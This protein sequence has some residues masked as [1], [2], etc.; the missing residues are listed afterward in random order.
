M[1][2][3]VRRAAFDIRLSNGFVWKVRSETMTAQWIQEM[4]AILGLSCKPG[5]PD[6]DLWVEQAE[7]WSGRPFEP[8]TL[9]DL[10]SHGLVSPDRWGIRAWPGLA[11]LRHEELAYVIGGLGK[12]S[13]REDRIEQ[14]RR[15][16]L[17]FYEAV[18]AQG[19]LPLHAALA[20]IE[21]NGVLLAGVSGA[22]KSTCCRRFP[23]PWRVL[24]DD[25]AS[26]VPCDDGTFRGHPLPTWSAVKAQAVERP[27]ALRHSVPVR[28]IFFLMH[29]DS[30][31]AVPMGG[32]R[33]ALSIY[34][35]AMQ[36]FMSVVSSTYIP[37]GSTYRRK[38]FE[39]AA[40]M[41]AA[42]PAFVLHVSLRGRFWECIERALDQVSGAV[43][44]N[45]G[46]TIFIDSL[47]G[48]GDRPHIEMA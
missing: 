42:V 25:M 35:A 17:P 3:F 13:Q 43:Y 4:A 21:G 26:V 32:A 19:G 27:C 30:D 47:R 29:N 15:A 38:L 36:V 12:V 24:G 5:T 18:T 1:H 41:T 6:A 45:K 44:K 10:S 9:W 46:Q 11:L 20:E 23:L 2:M 7:F 48:N 34:S 22:G 37:G 14:M 40:A 39:T 33:A 16:M 31:H 8:F 28:A